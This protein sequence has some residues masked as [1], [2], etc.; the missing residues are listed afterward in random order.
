[1]GFGFKLIPNNQEISVVS[2]YND[3]TLIAKRKFKKGEDV[4]RP[5]EVS[6]TLSGYTFVGWRSTPDAITRYETLEATGKAMTLY[7]Y[8]LPNS[9]RIVSAEKLWVDNNPKWV[10]YFKD[11]QYYTGSIFNES[12]IWY[13]PGDYFEGWATGTLKL[14]YY[15]RATFYTQA[16]GGWGDD[17]EGSVQ[18]PNGTLIW[19]ESSGSCTVGGTVTLHTQ[20]YGGSWYGAEAIGISN[21]T[22]SNPRAWG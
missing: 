14:G 7:A 3:S 21:I 5:S 20:G 10:E 15:Q 8:F 16:W 19:N 12:S 2:Y 6:P 22:L 17:Q 11:A 4:L 13:R 9:L 1:M 18:M